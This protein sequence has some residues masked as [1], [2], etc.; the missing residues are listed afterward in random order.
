MGQFQQEVVKYE[1]GGC[2]LLW[3]RMK[4][5]GLGI[6]TL[7]MWAKQDNPETYAKLISEDISSLIYKSLR[8]ADYDIALVIAR[9]F[10]HRFRCASHKH[11]VVQFE[12]HGWKEKERDTHCS[13]RTYRLCST[14]T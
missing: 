3:Y 6:G 12:G 4:E 11:H 5:G 2:E 10:K 8:F 14:N 7:H 13:T 1:A 9:M